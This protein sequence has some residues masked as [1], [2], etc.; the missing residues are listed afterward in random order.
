MY[1]A[2][3]PPSGG[4]PLQSILISLCLRFASR[5][6]SARTSPPGWRLQRCWLEAVRAAAGYIGLRLCRRPLQDSMFGHWGV[7]GWLGGWRWV[8]MGG[9]V[10]T[11]SRARVPAHGRPGRAAVSMDGRVGSVGGRQ[12][13]G[14]G[15]RQVS[16]PRRYRFRIQEAVPLNRPAAGSSLAGFESRR[17]RFRIPPGSVSNPTDTSRISFESH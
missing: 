8:A 17:Y 3:L 16:T 2:G 11:G 14:A 4:T 9:C 10:Y 5:V 6:P 7:R 1:G 12:Q 15:S 13:Y